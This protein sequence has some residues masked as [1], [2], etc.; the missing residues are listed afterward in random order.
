MK[1]DLRNKTPQQLEEI[2]YRL[3]GRRYTDSQ[4][5]KDI[6]AGQAD[7]DDLN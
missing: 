1:I 4:I 2:E 7:L 6:E 5:L 3:T